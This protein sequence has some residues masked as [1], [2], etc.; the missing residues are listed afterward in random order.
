MNNTT[1]RPSNTPNNALF[2]LNSVSKEPAKLVTH[3][4]MLKYAA[5]IQE[6]S[7]SA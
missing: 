3:H 6:G 1:I 2:L 7:Q 5:I 4:V